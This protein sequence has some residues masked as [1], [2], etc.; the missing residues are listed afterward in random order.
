MAIFLYFRIPQIRYC[1]QRQKVSP[2]RRKPESPRR[3]RKISG[4]WLCA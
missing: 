4:G 1:P 3:R 2:F